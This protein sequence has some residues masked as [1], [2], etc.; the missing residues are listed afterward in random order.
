MRPASEILIVSFNT[1]IAMG[2]WNLNLLIYLERLDE[3]D[4]A[5]YVNDVAGLVGDQ[6]EA[7]DQ[8]L[9]IFISDGEL[10][11]KIWD[12]SSC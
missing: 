5:L 11:H 1:L 3:P 7:V 8:A 2:I 4:V 9:K 10:C 6:L 12:W